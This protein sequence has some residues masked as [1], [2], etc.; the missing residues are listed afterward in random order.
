MVCQT[1]AAPLKKKIHDFIGLATGPREATLCFNL[2]HLQCC[3]VVVVVV[4]FSYWIL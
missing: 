2:A 3:F 4:L 1:E